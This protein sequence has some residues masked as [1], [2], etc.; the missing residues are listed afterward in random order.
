MNQP[1]Y[2]LVDLAVG[3]PYG[4][5][6]SSTQFPANLQIDYIRAYATT[7]A[8][9]VIAQVSPASTGNQLNLT[10]TAEGNSTVNIYEDNVLIGTA[11]ANGVGAWSFATSV[12]CGGH[13]SIYGN[14][15]QCCQQYQREFSRAFCHRLAPSDRCLDTVSWRLRTSISISKIAAGRAR[16]SDIMAA[17][18]R[19]VSSAVGRRSG[20][21]RPLAATMLP[22]EIPVL[23]STPSGQP[24]PMAITRQA[25]PELWRGPAPP[26]NRTNQSLVRT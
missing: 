15:H 25:R 16:R 13:S 12:P 5:P 17:V 21:C 4:N 23:A 18:S 8:P 7:A 26:S 20:P 22:G 2:M 1:M 6:T 9:P 11:A 14:G 10:G 24:T 19:R 3:G